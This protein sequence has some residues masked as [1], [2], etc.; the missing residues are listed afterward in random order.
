MCQTNLA[1][2]VTFR[3]WTSFNTPV[4]GLNVFL[5]PRFHLSVW[6]DEKQ[7]ASPSFFQHLP[8]ITASFAGVTDSVKPEDL[9]LNIK[10][11]V[12]NSCAGIN[13]SSSFVKE[14]WCHNCHVTTTWLGNPTRSSNWFPMRR[15]IPLSSALLAAR[16]RRARD[17]ASACPGTAE[18]WFLVL[19]MGEGIPRGSPSTFRLKDIG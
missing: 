4:N 19:Q 14:Q 16:L 12:H 1:S 10:Q 5:L 13:C 18:P 7:P 9:A 17:S 6:G 3:Q 8:I 11:Y 15:W 2:H